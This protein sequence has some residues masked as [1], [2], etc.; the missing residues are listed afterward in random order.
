MCIR[1]RRQQGVGGGHL[2]HPQ[3]LLRRLR[4]TIAL[5]P[6]ALRIALETQAQA[7]VV[8]QHGLQRLLQCTGVERLVRCQ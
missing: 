4:V 8:T 5:L 2:A 6:V 7:G 3:Q 1:D